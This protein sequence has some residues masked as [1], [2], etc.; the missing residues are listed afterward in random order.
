VFSDLNPSFSI[1]SRA[2][3]AWVGPGAEDEE[4]EEDDADVDADGFDG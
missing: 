1:I 2:I 4:D 3:R